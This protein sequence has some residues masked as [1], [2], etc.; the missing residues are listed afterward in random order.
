MHNLI[1]YSLSLT[2]FKVI[3][4]IT[5]SLTGIGIQRER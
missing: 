3:V 2:Y 4:M 1:G 5:R